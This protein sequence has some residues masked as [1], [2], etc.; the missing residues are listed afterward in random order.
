MSKDKT[1]AGYRDA[2]WMT[3]DEFLEKFTYGLRDHLSNKVYGTGQG[4]KLHHPTDLSVHTAAY[5]DIAY[6]V[7]ENFGVAPCEASEN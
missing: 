6:N 3:I 1:E 7:I 5:A 2:G 4:D